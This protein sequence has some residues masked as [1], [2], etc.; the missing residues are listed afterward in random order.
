MFQDILYTNSWQRN[1]A[2]PFCRLDSNSA[3]SCHQSYFGIYEQEL[4]AHSFCHARLVHASS[5]R[6]QV[7]WMSNGM[8]ELQDR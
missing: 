7:S 8:M 1:Q 6:G 3:E 5:G 2:S 4:K